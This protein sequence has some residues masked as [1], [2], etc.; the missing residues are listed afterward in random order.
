ME[1][2]ALLLLLIGLVMIG[3]INCNT[4][5]FEFTNNC[6]HPVWVGTLSGAGTPAL[7]QT[8]F[9]LPVGTSVDLSA[10][11]SWSG[12]FWGRTG[13]A[14]NPDTGKFCCDSAD[15]ATGSVACDGHGPTPPA[16]LVEVTLGGG[17][18]NDYYDVSLVDG[19]NVP[20]SIEPVDGT[21]DCRLTACS[22]NLNTDCPTDLKV[23]ASND[24]V[25]GC[26]SACDAFEEPRFCCTGDYGSP[27]TCGPSNY[28]QIFKEACPS[29]YSYAYDD[30]SSVFTCVGA[31]Y[32][33]TFCP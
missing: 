4:T 32:V 19:F 8:G 7:E 27:S 18:S 2:R 10:P 15:C 20:I 9:H 33:V 25:V 31:S 6:Q 14:A 21:G 11:L 12:R 3:A 28:S 5:T 26:K 23:T 13:C 29:A 1:S 24:T 17:T 16:T 22:A 30:A